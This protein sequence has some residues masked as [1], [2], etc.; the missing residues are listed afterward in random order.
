MARPVDDVERGGCGRIVT[1]G[2]DCEHGKDDEK[3]DGSGHGYDIALVRSVVDAVKI[4]VIALGGV[5]EWE[6]LEEGIVHGGASAV[7]AGNI[8]HYTENSVY[9]AKRHLFESGLNV[10]EPVLFER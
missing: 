6:H 8:F 5:G 7:A 2:D 4:P 1:A 3:Q 10:R 9:H